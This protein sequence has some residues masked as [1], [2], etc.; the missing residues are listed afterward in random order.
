[1]KINSQEALKLA[2]NDLGNINFIGGYLGYLAGGY[3]DQF[4]ELLHTIDESSS[5]NIAHVHSYLG[6][7]S[8]VIMKS[9][10]LTEAS[11][12]FK[13]SCI[14][15]VNAGMVL[16]VTDDINGEYS[17]NLQDSRFLY[18][19]FKT[20]LL[21][22]KTPSELYNMTVTAFS[23]SE[24]VGLPII[25]RITNSLADK[26]FKQIIHKES[27]KEV[28]KVK[29]RATKNQKKWI[30]HPINTK[31]ITRDHVERF[32]SIKDFPEIDF[33]DVRYNYDVDNKKTLIYS[34]CLNSNELEKVKNYSK[35]I[36]LSTFPVTSKHLKSKIIESEHIDI[37]DMESSFLSE[38]IGRIRGVNNTSIEKR[39]Y[40]WT[41]SME[42]RCG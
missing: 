18:N 29:R 34:Q 15:G 32:N 7:R 21:E 38:E 20:I 16:V 35:I 31:S 2:I 42:N 33:N 39:S 6:K 37:I 24:K 8:L 17:E 4:K 3:M 12:A 11:L 13:N 26:E 10:G 23:V 36:S 14:M 1:M 22:P 25:I 19:F 40:G 28:I 41:G 27:V 30:L 5:V 9:S